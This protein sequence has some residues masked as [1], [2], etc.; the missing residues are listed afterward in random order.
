M[1]AQRRKLSSQ[2]FAAEYVPR[3]RNAATL[4]TLMILPDCRAEHALQGGVGELHG[5]FDVQFQVLLLVRDV[6]VLEGPQQADPRV[7]DQ[8]L[9]RPGGIGEAGDDG[10]HPASSVRSAAIVSAADAVAVLQ[11]RRRGR[12][13]A[14]VAGHEHHAVALF[15]Q[16]AGE[17]GAD[18]CCCA[19][20]QGG[21]AGSEWLCVGS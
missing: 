11:L 16:L 20:D 13:A 19:R 18:A 7:V 3:G 8:D 17:F 2:A 12:E 10:G 9:H 21:G 14:G 1:L 15:G 6:V 5:G 4:A